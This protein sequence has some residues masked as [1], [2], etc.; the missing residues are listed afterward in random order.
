MSER[1]LAK[2]GDRIWVKKAAWLRP[3]GKPDIPENWKQMQVWLDDG[4]TY[5]LDAEFVA[6]NPIHWCDL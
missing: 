1:F 5:I 3:K 6:S 4:S 2:Q